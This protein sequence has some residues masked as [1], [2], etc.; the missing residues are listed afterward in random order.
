MMRQTGKTAAMVMAAKQAQLEG[1]PV[2]IYTVDQEY[3]AARLASYG[4]L[5]LLVGDNYVSPRWR[6]VDAN[7][8]C[9]TKRL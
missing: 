6:E 4:A 5:C 9:G 1:I 7:N 8:L 3:T 2:M